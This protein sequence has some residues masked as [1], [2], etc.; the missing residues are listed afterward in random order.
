M[1]CALLRPLGQAAGCGCLDPDA[2]LVTRAPR[3]LSGGHGDGDRMRRSFS[4]GRTCPSY[5]NSDVRTL[6]RWERTRGL[7]IRRMPGGTGRASIA[8][9]SELDTVAALCGAAHRRPKSLRTIPRPHRLLRSC[10]F[11]TSVP[12]SKIGTSPT[13]SP[14]RS[15]RRSHACRGSDVIARTSSFASREREQDVREIGRRLNV[16]AV[17]EGSVRRSGSRIRFTAQLVDTAGGRSPLERTFR[18]APDGH[19]RRPG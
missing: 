12:T 6:Q 19:V 2:A 1:R 3:V 5:L 8:I 13:D 15:S 11:S 14:T 7:P 9:K 10:R 4:P 18:S 17:L 16:R